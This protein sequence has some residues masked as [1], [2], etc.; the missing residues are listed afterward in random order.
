VVNRVLLRPLPYPQPDRI[1][2]VMRQYP[3]EGYGT[4]V[5]IPKFMTWRQNE[6]FE[7][8][9]TYIETTTGVNV[10]AG[11]RPEHAKSMRVSDEYFRVFGTP[12]ALGRTFTRAEDAPNGPAVAVLSHGFWQARLGGDTGILGKAIP[13][14]GKPTTIIGVLPQAFISDPP[15]D[16]WLP[17]QADPHSTNQGHFLAV[18]GRLKPGV[19]VE[20][21]RAAMKVLGERFRAENPKWMDKRESVAVVPLQEAKVRGVRKAILILMGAVAFV[22]LIACANVANLLLARAAARQKEL[23]VRAAIGASR[24]RV[25]RQLLTE[26]ALLA[27]LGGLL[28]FALGS[29]GVRLLLMLAPGNIPRLTDPDELH[30]TIPALDWRVA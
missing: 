2:Q 12:A 1:M 15:A 24:G 20:T 22:L 5:S 3:G 14:D 11:D 25:V 18:V 6:M 27:A 13:I 30:S 8:F 17:L 16:V 21:A 19:S 10:G 29:W 4:S 7:S 28:G 23:A 9:T 26:S